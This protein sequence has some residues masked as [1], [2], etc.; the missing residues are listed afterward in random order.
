MAAAAWSWVEKM[1]QE[2]QRISAPSSSSVSISTAVWMVM[3][4]DPVMRAP[5]SGLAAAYSS[6][7]AMRPGIS[8]SAM[9]ISLRPQAG[10]PRSATWKSVKFSGLVRAFMSV[11]SSW[12]GDL[13]RGWA[14]GS[15]PWQATV[16]E[17]GFDAFRAWRDLASR[18][19]APRTPHILAETRTFDAV[20]RRGHRV[21]AYAKRA[22]QPPLR[23][24]GNHDGHIPTTGMQGLRLGDRRGRLRGR[25]GAPRLRG[26]RLR[27]R[28]PNA[29]AAAAGQSPGPGARAADA[30]R[31]GDDRE[32]RDRALPERPRATLRP[33]PAQR[34]RAA[35]GFPALERVPRGGRVSDLH[36]R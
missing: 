21:T 32:P 22:I 10:R 18:C 28:E 25:E 9:A 30:R 12:K 36:V 3:C 13:G 11:L 14:C 27:R 29:R 2:A 17:R 20:R 26:S 31:L 8:V 34:R 33:H 1:L 23:A 7:I 24:Q 5:A 35:Y 19:N 15:S 16:H 6:R 4:S